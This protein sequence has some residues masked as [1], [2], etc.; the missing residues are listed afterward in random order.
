MTARVVNKK[1]YIDTPA[2]LLDIDKLDAN[3]KKVSDHFRG[4]DADLR[5]HIKTHKCPVLAHKQIAAGAI[6]V[7]CAKVGETEVMARAGITDILIAN[8][9]ISP[10]K[11]MRLLDLL[12]ISDVK[13]AV[14]SLENITNL[15]AAA[16]SRKTV[17]KVLIEVD[18]GMHRCGVAT[19]DEAIELARK[20][21]KMKHVE[22]AGIMGYEGHIIFTYDRDERVKLGTECMEYLVGVK[23]ELETAGFPIPIVSGGGTGTYDIASKVPGVTEVQAG[24]YLTMDATYGY[25]NMGFEQAVTL[26]TTVIAVHGDHVIVDCGMKSITSEFGMPQPL[27]L[28]GVSLASLSEEHGHLNVEGKT[29]L[30]VGDLVELVPTH[31]C[32]TINLHDRFHPVRGDMV[33]GIWEISARGKFS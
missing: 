5:P 10:A 31:G 13:V 33:E 19:S 17:L 15:N 29:K 8:Q 16:E 14:E 4:V 32:T 9:V 22:L 21:A 3:L 6:G 23:Q 27:G 7:T 2:L 28:E 1:A 18:V 30:K 25:L 24:S 11:I 20:I 12:N 26:L